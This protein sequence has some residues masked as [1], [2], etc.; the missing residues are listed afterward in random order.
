MPEKNILSEFNFFSDLT[1]QELDLLASK[2][3][4]LDFNTDDIVFHFEK[5]AEHFYGLISGEV[6]LSLVF[7]DK[8][9][10]TEVEYEEAVQARIVDQQK[11]IVV[12]TVF[13]GQVFGWASIIGDGKR[14][15][16]ARCLEPSRAF[17]IAASDLYAMFDA[18]PSLGYRMIKR[19]AYIISK[20]LKT[21]TDKLIEAWVEA[22][23]VDNI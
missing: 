12:D 20:R 9:L 4:E 1:M 13:P 21:R 7:T 8:V 19:M 2:C 14:T 3:E 18:D 15:V 17:A 6:E 10:K 16:T 23:D 11:Q 22:F 5:P